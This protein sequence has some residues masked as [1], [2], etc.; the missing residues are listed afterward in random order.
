MKKEKREFGTLIGGVYT[1]AQDEVW[2]YLGKMKEEIFDSN[3]SEKISEKTGNC[4]WRVPY[5]GRSYEIKRLKNVRKNHIFYGSYPEV[6][7]LKGYKLIDGMMGIAAHLT[8]GLDG[9]YLYRYYS[10][11]PANGVSNM[12]FRRISYLN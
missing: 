7:F 6:I 3:M 4:Y 1:T 10:I 8:Q 12:F 5:V 11:Y 9:D 2:I